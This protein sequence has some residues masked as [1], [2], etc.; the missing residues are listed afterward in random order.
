M[1]AAYHDRPNVIAVILL[2]SLSKLNNDR[3]EKGICA[4]DHEG[5]TAAQIAIKRCSV[6]SL[7]V[8]LHLYPKLTETVEDFSSH[9]CLID[10]A[11]LYCS[12]SDETLA[13]FSVHYP[14]IARQILDLKATHL[15]NSN[16]KI[17]SESVKDSVGKLYRKALISKLQL[18]LAEGYKSLRKLPKAMVFTSIEI[19]III[20][21][22]I[23]GYVSC[24]DKTQKHVQ[25]LYFSGIILVVFIR[26]LYSKLCSESPG[27]FQVQ[28]DQH[29]YTSNRLH[30]SDFEAGLVKSERT[31]GDALNMVY[32]VSN[33]ARKSRSQQL[34]QVENMEDLL[35]TNFCCHYCRTYRPLRSIHSK[36]LR[37]CIPQ[38]DHYCIF[39]GNHVGRDNYPYYISSLVAAVGVV[40][41][42]FIA[43]LYYYL[44][45]I[46][47]IPGTNGI[48]DTWSTL[49]TSSV[50]YSSNEKKS[51]IMKEITF[52][53]MY[54]LMPVFVLF[55]DSYIQS[56]LKYFLFWSC[57]WWFVFLSLLSL[58]LYLICIDVTT[59]ECIDSFG[60]T[61]LKGKGKLSTSS[62]NF[63]FSNIFIRIFP[64]MDDVC[65]T[66]GDL[67]RL[68]GRPLL[69][70]S[71]CKSRIFLALSETL[72][73]KVHSDIA[74]ARNH[75]SC[76][77]G[78]EKCK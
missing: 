16:Y 34:E 32:S 46:H 60:T 27:S 75:G 3:T 64:T 58:H 29:R 66:S 62:R 53:D 35:S 37:R 23:L 21:I 41:P 69:S 9:P 63:R 44:Y 42:L 38:F 10:I 6:A 78:K 56:P 4:R 12:K 28:P 22:H 77:D 73:G 68:Q 14:D 18:C 47:V 45:H 17:N 25:L 71:D 55:M 11:A 72:F 57:L 54:T 30:G 49:I 39:L 65:Y 8:L 36:S 15:E 52:L 33:I 74:S 5:L 61:E 26:L 1:I 19:A 48:E 13:F 24:L 76:F 7:S 70:L 20:S 51:S 43:N 67:Q 50:T 40:M 31:Y 2:N 59:R